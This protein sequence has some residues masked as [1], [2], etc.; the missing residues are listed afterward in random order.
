MAALIRRPK[1]FFQRG[2]ST[3]SS[4]TMERASLTALGLDDF[5]VFDDEII[6]W[7]QRRAQ[8]RR[9]RAVCLRAIREAT[10]L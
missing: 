4:A 5:T 1:V 8:R 7:L 2:G 10:S 3:S 9:V 6:G